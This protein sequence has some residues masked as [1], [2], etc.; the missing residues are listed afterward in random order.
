MICILVELKIDVIENYYN[1]VFGNEDDCIY[2]I[3]VL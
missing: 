3:W 1:V 2:V